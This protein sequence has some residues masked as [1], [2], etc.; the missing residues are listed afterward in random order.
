MDN[1]A[2]SIIEADAS[3]FKKQAGQSGCDGNQHVRDKRVEFRVTAIE[4]AQLRAM[5]LA[6][7]CNSLA[8]Y[9]REAALSAGSGTI[10]SNAYHDQLK[11]L[12]EIN[13]IGTHVEEISAK[14]RGGREPDEETLVVLLQI[15]ELA[16]Q[17]WQEA[18]SAKK[19]DHA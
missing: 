12:Q 2:R 1:G 8:Q 11:W 6:N 3:Q 7:G 19:T 5:A 18:K 14:L 17:V 4:H 10:P 13:R 16:E 15:Q 9:A